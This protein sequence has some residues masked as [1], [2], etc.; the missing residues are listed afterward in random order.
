MS[1]PL[2][3]LQA[4]LRMLFHG[5]I[6]HHQERIGERDC[7]QFAIGEYG[8]APTAPKTGVSAFFDKDGRLEGI[9]GN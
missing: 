6:K 2:T 3:D 7:V 8:D 5:N 4:L 9:Y 1:D